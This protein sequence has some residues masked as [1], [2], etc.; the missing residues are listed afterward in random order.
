MDEMRLFDGGPLVL[1]IQATFSD[2][3]GWRAGVILRREGECWEEAYR[4]EYSHLTT[5]ELVDTLDAE[6][7]RHL[8]KR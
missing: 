4:S 2:G 1:H 3:A 5:T 7:E 8:G 6:I